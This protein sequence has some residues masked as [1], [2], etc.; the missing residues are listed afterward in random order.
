MARR[1][2]LG[3]LM[4]SLA[5]LTP[6]V[7][8]APRAWAGDDAPAAAPVDDKFVELVLAD[9]RVI[10]AELISESATEYRV[11]AHLMEGFPAVETTF[12]KS[13]VKEIRRGVAIAGAST[14]TTK[15]ETAK[16]GDSK[17]AATPDPKSAEGA[18]KIILTRV[19]G[20]VGFDF[21]PTPLTKF[22]E[23]VDEEFNDIGPDGHV[24]SEHRKDH[25]VVFRF[26]TQ[27]DVRQGL[28]GM[29]SIMDLKN[30]LDEEINKGR[31]IVFWVEKGLN[32]AAIL[33]MMSPEIYFTDRGVLYVTDDMEDFS[34]GDPVVRE[35][36]I[37][38]RVVHAQGFPIRGGYTEVGPPLILA[39]VRRTY[40]FWYKKVGD[41]VYATNNTPPADEIDQWIQLS[42]N[43]TGDNKDDAD[44]ITTVFGN[45]RVW[46]D[47]ERAYELGISK[48]VANSLDDIAFHLG[49]GRHYQQVLKDGGEDI[50]RRWRG[51]LERSLA[52]I[53]TGQDGRPR[54]ELWREFD[55]AD[56]LGTAAAVLGKR[57]NTLEK[58]VAQLR[59]YK[60]VFDP[61]GQ[62]IA[63]WNVQIE[64]LKQQIRQ[65]N[66][67]ANN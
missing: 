59:K 65:A 10:K 3:S 8:P 41:K 58:I 20:D 34:F 7:V 27:T 24:V 49:V 39:M 1:W 17:P 14:P 38:L 32:G 66:S 62:Q 42:D 48:G 40:E 19:D 50:F 61:D 29:F 22:F 63:Q 16:P 28:T 37:S 30:I 23:L 44:D 53:A 5:M 43:G 56:E 6:L 31:R 67:Q 18:A 21:S 33:P 36:Q 11:L 15:P 60:E 35:K 57:K 46:L 13:N 64:L 2:L 51:E 55:K 45:D 4:L 12:R 25:I 54:G 52:Q 26:N 47:A 9:G